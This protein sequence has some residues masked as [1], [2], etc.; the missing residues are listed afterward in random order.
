MSAIVAGSSGPIEQQ[1]RVSVRK[2]GGSEYERTWTGQHG[3]MKA[4]F[5]GL[6]GDG[7]T[8]KEFI[9]T[10][11]SPL[12]VVRAR[13]ARFP[14]DLP[15]EEISQTL[16]IRFNSVPIPINQHSYFADILGGGNND[17]NMAAIAELDRLV[18]ERSPLSSGDASLIGTDTGTTSKVFKYYWHR[19]MRIDSFPAK[20]PVVT[21]TRTVA[22]DYP[23][24]L[25]VES[26]GQIF[27]TDQVSERT[28]TPLLFVVPTPDIFLEDTFGM[29]STGWQ[30]D[31]QVDYLADGSVQL[32]EQYEWGQYSTVTTEAGS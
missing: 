9:P 25:E 3:S 22:E 12:A 19:R 7:L 14:G 4:L 23:G 26:A 8:E 18:E 27:T 10:P 16:S 30:L 13:Y 15:D 28:F 5:S 31:S 6:A 21:Y 24:S 1:M 20:L 32:V 17:A 29:M 2:V 11:G